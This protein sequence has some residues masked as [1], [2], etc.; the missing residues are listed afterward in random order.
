MRVTELIWWDW[1][2]KISLVPDD[3]NP[4]EVSTIDG[5]GTSVDQGINASIGSCT[6]RPSLSVVLATQASIRST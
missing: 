4:V 2:I 6:V 3:D 1:R 5:K